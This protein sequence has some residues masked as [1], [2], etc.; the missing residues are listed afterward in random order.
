MRIWSDSHSPS[1]FVCSHKDLFLL[2]IL[3]L[4]LL[5][6]CFYLPLFLPR[7]ILWVCSPPGCPNFCLSQSC[8]QAFD[9]TDFSFDFDF[10]IVFHLSFCIGANLVTFACL[11]CCRVCDYL[12]PFAS[13]G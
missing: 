10:F 3:I 11:V 7:P 9:L 8:F 1:D 4:V 6:F 13:K 2:R 5:L 12:T